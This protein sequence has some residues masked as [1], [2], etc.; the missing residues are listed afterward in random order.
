MLF[1]SNALPQ[2]DLEQWY[3]EHRLWGRRR[4][5]VLPRYA[6][7]PAGASRRLR[8]GYV[9]ADLREHATAGFLRPIL[10]GHDH[11]ASRYSATAMRMRPTR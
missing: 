8:I 5:D 10:A 9:S 2:R 11:E 4:A 1:M 3:A 7:A 6:H